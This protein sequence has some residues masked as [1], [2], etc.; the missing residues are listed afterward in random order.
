MTTIKINGKTIT[1]AN[2]ST[3]SFDIDKESIALESLAVDISKSI[4][5]LDIV[6]DIKAMEAFGYKSTEGVGE[7]IKAGAI[8]VWEKIKQFF[9]KIGKWIVDMF[10]RGGAKTRAASLLKKLETMD[11][12]D[13]NF[14][15]KLNTIKM[16]FKMTGKHSVSEYF[17]SFTTLGPIL[18]FYVSLLNGTFLHESDNTENINETVTN[19]IKEAVEKSP[20]LKEFV[21]NFGGLGDIK[22]NNDNPFD[23]NLYPLTLKGLGLS[24]KSSIIQFLKGVESENNIVFQT[25][26]ECKVVAD[27]AQKTISDLE[28]KLENADENDRKYLKAVSNIAKMTSNLTKYIWSYNNSIMVCI[29]EAISQKKTNNE[30][31]TQ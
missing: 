12:N 16:S 31:Q 22:L 1:I 20:A 6:S 21:S 19:S 23:T 11:E 24:N 3:E 28:K 2:K 30:T 13:I 14:D 5:A 9:I 7:K 8:A 18:K 29:S 15:F 4:E 27:T 26:K 10:T 17:K 25:L